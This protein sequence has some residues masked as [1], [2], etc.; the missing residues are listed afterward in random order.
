MDERF[1]K[2]NPDLEQIQTRMNNGNHGSDSRYENIVDLFTMLV[3]QKEPQKSVLAHTAASSSGIT[4]VPSFIP[5]T[6]THVSTMFT[7]A[8]SPMV[9]LFLPILLTPFYT[10]LASLTTLHHLSLLPL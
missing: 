10:Y 1:D 2:T 4:H 7:H 5:L 9:P 3:A 8:N 6:S